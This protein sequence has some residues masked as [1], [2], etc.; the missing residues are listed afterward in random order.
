MAVGENLSHAFPL[1]FGGCWQTLTFLGLKM[2]CSNLCLHYYM[3]FIP[4][5]CTCISV[6]SSCKDIRYIGLG[7]TLIQYGPTLIDLQR[8]YF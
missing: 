4:R 3:V 1:A 7:P 6:F 8:P 2:H 5:V